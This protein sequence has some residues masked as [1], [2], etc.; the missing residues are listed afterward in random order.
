MFV[1]G[2]VDD[3]YLQS[4]YNSLSHS[5]TVITKVISELFNIHL[6]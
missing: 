3:Q 5:A 2:L 1:F 6:K 4:G